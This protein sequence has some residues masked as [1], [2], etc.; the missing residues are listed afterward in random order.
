M[1]LGSTLEMPGATPTPCVNQKMPAD[2]VKRPLAYK[3]SV[4]KR[5]INN[6]VVEFKS[7]TECP[8]E[9]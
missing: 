1:S 6:V 4:V 8:F 3:L 7:K 2:I 5:T 9:E